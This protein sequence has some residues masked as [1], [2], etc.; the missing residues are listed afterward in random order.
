MAAAPHGM[1]YWLV[2]ATGDVHRFGDAA[3]L[4]DLQTSATVIDLAPRPQADG[5]WMATGDARPTTYQAASGDPS[6][7]DFDRLAQCESSGNWGARGSYEG[8]LQFLNSTWL[9]YGG[10]EFATHAYDASRL[11][12]IEIGRRVWRDKGWSAWPSCSRQIGYR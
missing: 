12:Q 11:Q 2:T 1:G 8:G 7:A 3:D 10:G 4:G 9:G 5:Y 6:D